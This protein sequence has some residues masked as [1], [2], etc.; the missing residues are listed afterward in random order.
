M[1]QTIKNVLGAAAA[2]AVLA[3]GY[4]ALSY[5][6]AYSKVIE[7]SSFRSF[8]VS[9]EGKITAI[10]D[11]AAFSFQVITEG[12]TDVAG[13]QAKNSAATNEAISFI[14]EKG[15]DEK[16]IKTEYYNVNPR[17][18]TYN[19][20]PIPYGLSSAIQPCPPAAIVGYTVTQSV[21]VKIRDFAKIGDIMGGV[22]DKG[23]NQVG[24]LS[25]TIDDPSG[26]YDEARAEAISRAR[27]KAES[28]ADAGGFS[29]GRLLNIQEGSAYP[30]YN[31]SRMESLDMKA[32]D[33]ASAAPAIQPGSQDISVTVTMQ[34][35]IK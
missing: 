15:V 27:E 33:A 7:P 1:T 6:N 26:V 14:K 31:Y 30:I 12:G 22:V 35:E 29:V 11:I 24:S 2:L 5:V 25:F 19:C 18:E 9:G 21:S 28:I 10:P 16:D 3:L 34:Y 17:Y 13:L 20:S 32:G 8:S 4:A 23:A